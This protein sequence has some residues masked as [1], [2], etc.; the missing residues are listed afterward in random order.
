MSEPIFY[1][2]SLRYR[3]VCSHNPEHP[4]KVYVDI[5]RDGFCSHDYMF[6]QQKKKYN[7]EKLERM[8]NDSRG[9]MLKEARDGTLALIYTSHKDIKAREAQKKKRALVDPLIFEVFKK[10]KEEGKCVSFSMP[11]V[12][13]AEERGA[14]LKCEG[15]VQSLQDEMVLQETLRKERLEKLKQVRHDFYAKQKYAAVPHLR[16]M[17]RQAERL[18]D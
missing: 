14:I 13:Y 9:I 12:M 6:E 1:A 16:L 18:G 15:N 4:E 11:T 7:D 17:L 8:F 2:M 10:M 3:V 5:C